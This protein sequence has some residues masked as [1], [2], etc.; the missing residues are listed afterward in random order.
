ML[1]SVILIIVGVVSVFV[2][3]FASPQSTSGA[4]RKL[5]WA[6]LIATAVIIV[7][8]GIENIRSNRDLQL[9]KREAGAIRRLDVA[10]V[11]TLAGNWK[12]TTPPDFSGYLRTG[13]RG[14]N[15][16]VELKTKDNAGMR[17]IE[18]TDS[19]PPRIVAGERNT[20]VLD[21]TSQASA[22]S[23]I[24]G[25]SRD[26]LETCGNVVMRLYGI[27]HNATKDGVVT[28]NSLIL[29]F[30]VNGVLAYRCEYHPALRMQ[31]TPELGSPVRAELYGPVEMERIESPSP[32]L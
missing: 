31:L 6:A 10:A 23:W 32:I 18:F 5:A 8:S 24:L 17:W 25:V 26:D 22:G 21:Y 30:F 20:W 3:S 11:V 9:V 7:Y 14:V 27:D 28:L 15:I 1:K 19:S 2:L 13:E 12:S 16:R 29:N 4:V